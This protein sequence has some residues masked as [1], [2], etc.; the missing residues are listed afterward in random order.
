[1]LLFLQ[2]LAAALLWKRNRGEKKM[3]N[4]RERRR[5]VCVGGGGGSGVEGHLVYQLAYSLDL[6]KPWVSLSLGRV[7]LWPSRRAA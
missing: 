5:C 3:N 1:M 2:R 4:E 6:G 7:V